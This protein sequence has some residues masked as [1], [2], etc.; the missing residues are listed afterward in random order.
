MWSLLTD[1]RERCN[2]ENT[3]WRWSTLGLALGLGTPIAVVDGG[4]LEQGGEDKDEAHD[5]VD[6]D[7]FDVRDARQRRPDTCTDGRHRQH[8]RYTC[9]INT[10]SICIN[11]LSRSLTVPRSLYLT[12]ADTVTLEEGKKILHRQHR[13][14]YF[15]WIK[16]YLD[17]KYQYTQ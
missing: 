6:V 7:S 11:R 13:Y 15:W 8:G 1:I 2:R 16:T 4:V 9:I 14:Y 5:Q 12:A 3:Y 17:Y 10:I